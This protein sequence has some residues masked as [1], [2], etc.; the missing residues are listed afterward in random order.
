MDSTCVRGE[1]W[2]LPVLSVGRW[3]YGG[4]GVGRGPMSRTRHHEG[5]RVAALAVGRPDWA[6]RLYSWR[7]SWK[8]GQPTSHHKGQWKGYEGFGGDYTDAVVTCGGNSVAKCK[9]Q[10]GGLHQLRP[11][12][13]LRDGTSSWACTKGPVSVEY[14]LVE[15]F[16]ARDGHVNGDVQPRVYGS[17]DYF[18]YYLGNQ[19]L[20]LDG[21]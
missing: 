6:N 19:R 15:G 8:N 18:T 9:S 1:S 12:S 16:S 17:Q 13:S 5:L 3:K 11:S 2:P 14:V 4:L 20:L 7:S 10:G 21:T